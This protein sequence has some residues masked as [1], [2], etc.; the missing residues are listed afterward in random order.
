MSA[1]KPMKK[2]IVSVGRI[3]A[4][5]AVGL[6]TL[7]ALLLLAGGIAVKLDL[8]TAAIVTGAIILADVAIDPLTR[9][10]GPA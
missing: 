6:I 7:A 4:P 2:L 1:M 5:R 10:G 3:L 8:A 9:R